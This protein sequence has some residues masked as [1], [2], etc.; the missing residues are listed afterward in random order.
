MATQ[1]LVSMAQD[2]M[3]YRDGLEVSRALSL[4]Q[5]YSVRSHVT[6]QDAAQEF[7]DAERGAR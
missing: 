4:L 5:S 1:S 2:A 7:V 3:R 6:L